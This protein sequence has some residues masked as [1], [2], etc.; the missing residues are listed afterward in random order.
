MSV[1]EATTIINVNT[2]IVLESLG[3]RE[4]H[5]G[6]WLVDDL[7]AELRRQKIAIGFGTVRDRREFFGTLEGIRRNA[8]DLGRR[9][10]L[11]IDAH[12]SQRDGLRLEP[13]GE[14]VAW[15][16]LADACREIN[17][18]SLNNL[19]VVLASCHGFHA[20]LNVTIKDLTPFCTL[21]GPTGIIHAGLIQETFSKF[22]R[23]LFDT[24]DFSAA[25]SDLPPEFQ[26]F[27]AERILVN[28]YFG[29]LRDRCRG[30]GRRE[31][32]E[33]MLSEIVDRGVPLKLNVARKE[34]KAL[35]RPDAAAFDQFK[36][37]FLMSDHPTNADRFPSTHDDLLASLGP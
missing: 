3:D 1:Y 13:S 10:I 4:L 34:L 16:E 12:G 31:R 35:T 6:T 32:V 11:H 37:A 8:A 30:K 28:A 22:Y 17:E 24:N 25:L 23:K 33:R 27:H 19:V 14:F 15:S 7:S 36:R 9:F 20:V 29:Y 5:T 18:A 26:V 21:I 2:L